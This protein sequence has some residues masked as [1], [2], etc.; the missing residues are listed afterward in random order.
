MT[1][2]ILSAAI[3][4]VICFILHLASLVIATVRCRADRRH[5]PPPLDAP[6]VTLL[7]PVCG[8][9]NYC[10]ATLRSTF[11]LDYPRYEVLFCAAHAYGALVEAPDDAVGLRALGPGARVIDVFDREIEFILVPQRHD[12]RFGCPPIR[13]GGA[14]RHPDRSAPRLGLRFAVGAG[15]HMPG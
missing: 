9:E 5:E 10:E 11:E 15:H 7:R 12:L 14:L 8:M 2:A 13:R 3:F 4:C 6:A 1:I